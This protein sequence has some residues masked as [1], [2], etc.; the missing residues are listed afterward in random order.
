[1]ANFAILRV[2]KIKGAG[3]LKASGKH[4]FREQ[5][6]RNADAARTHLNEISGASSAENLVKCV[7]ALLPA[8]Q[9]VTRANGEKVTTKRRKDAVTCLE[10]LVTASPEWFGED[11]R[12]KPVVPGTDYFRDALAWL[13]AKHGKENIVCSTVHV[14]E[15]T[16]H[17]AVYV[18]PRT[19]D[20]RLS[21]KDF[22]GGGKKALSQMQTDFWKGVGEKHGLERGTEKSQAIHQDNAKIVP[23]SAE[24]VKLRK[25]VKA[26][27]AEIE[28]LTQQVTTSGGALA[29]AVKRFEKQQQ[30]NVEYFNVEQRLNAEL[31]EA[32]LS[33]SDL[34]QKLA[35]AVHLATEAGVAADVQRKE[36]VRLEKAVQILA[37][38][39]EV[40]QKAPA[41]AVPTPATALSAP[42]GKAW[43]GKEV[44]TPV[45]PPATVKQA[46]EA[47][48]RAEEKRLGFKLDRHGPLAGEIRVKV[49]EE[50]DAAEA[51][52]LAPPEPPKELEREKP[53]PRARSVELPTKGRGGRG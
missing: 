40:A 33:V 1:M 25:Q 22:I 29:A 17:M 49:R 13:A 44:E 8:S 35:V 43:M 28:R 9:V 4:N 26:L 37:E 21:A 7:A 52:R 53:R 34:R 12:D 39:R 3:Q 45:A 51:A 15:S 16:P 2:E 19:R 50:W 31:A 5:E 18:V 46:Q 36:V 20:G 11:W 42:G 14:D 38:E 27:E 41:V 6:T 32:K 48:I 24:L 30:I 10:Y 47:A 23:M